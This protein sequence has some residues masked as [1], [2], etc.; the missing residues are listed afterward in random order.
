MLTACS[1]FA[2]GLSPEAARAP[3]RSSRHASRPAVTGLVAMA[4]QPRVVVTGCGVVTA[5]GSGDEFW[6]ALLAGKSG[7]DTITHF[8]ASRFPCTVGAEVKDFDPKPY[9]KR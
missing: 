4:D 5:I 6:E 8:D 2:L 1:F 3:L 9:F 7:V